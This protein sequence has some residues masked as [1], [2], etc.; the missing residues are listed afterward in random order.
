M[1]KILNVTFINVF[2]TTGVSRFSPWPLIY[3]HANRN[4]DATC[5]Q[6]R[7]C[8]L[9]FDCSHL[10]ERFVNHSSSGHSRLR[11][12]WEQLLLRTLHVESSGKWVVFRVVKAKN[13]K[14]EKLHP[15]VHN[16]RRKHRR[17]VLTL[18]STG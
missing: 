11:L 4:V 2:F 17:A 15:L 6:C 3:S 14:R 13:T 8:L 7:F 18:N 16:A 1:V 10:V 9:T 12:Q 5:N